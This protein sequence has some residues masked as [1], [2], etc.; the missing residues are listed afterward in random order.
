MSLEEKANAVHLTKEQ[1]EKISLIAHFGWGYKGH[2]GNDWIVATQSAIW[3]ELGT[4]FQ[5]TSKYYPSDPWKYVISTPKEIVEHMKEIEKNIMEYK[6]GVSFG[7][8]IV[9]IPW[10]GSVSLED[11]N[12]QLREFIVS[13]E[14]CHYSINEDTIQIRPID[15]Q[16][17]S[18]FLKKQ[19]L[20]WERDFIVYYS[21]SGQNVIV[22]GDVTPMEQKISF[23]VVSGSLHLH[24]YDMDS[25]SCEPKKGGTLKGS[26]YHVF[27]ENGTFVKELVIDEN[28]NAS[29]S[30]L[31]LGR[32]YVQEQK[33]GENYEIDETKYFFDLSLDRP[34]Q[35]LVV[36]DRMYLGQL[37]IEKRDSKTKTCQSITPYA[38]LNGAIYGLY[39]SNGTL[40]EKLTILKDCSALSERN[41]LLGDYYIQELQAPKGYNLDTK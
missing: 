10:N 14:Q 37:K 8:S 33:A 16:N 38:T 36:Y 3:K 12:H 26:I 6:K 17:G 18:L 25:K 13:C 29:I 21:S 23:E 40:I 7:H 30:G 31:E 34:N 1:L 32:Y 11:T 19:N 20:F 41:L 35:E 15:N 9:K 22:P 24:K 28:C 2:S 4:E 39:K 5:F 27:T